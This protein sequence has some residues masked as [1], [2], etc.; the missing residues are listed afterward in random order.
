MNPAERLLT[1]KLIEAEPTLDVLGSDHKVL[2]V[3]YRDFMNYIKFNLKPID[4]Q[5]ITLNLDEETE[6]LLKKKPNEFES[7][8]VVWIGM[9]LKKWN[10]RVKLLLGKQNRND[11][12]NDTETTEPFQGKPECKRE[13][14]DMVI[15]TLIKNGEIC[16]T[17]ILSE[18]LLKMEL[19]KK[20]NHGNQSKEGLL[21]LLNDTLR[22]AREMTKSS[23]PLI[24]VLVDK[25]YYNAPKELR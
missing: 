17:E 12:T 9:W 22:K 19:N 14:I 25:D 3:A 11:C 23:G 15:S 4:E 13:I 21:C 24:F 2:Q 10:G 5:T 18:H 6:T 8:L 1:K 7:F 16:G 20:T